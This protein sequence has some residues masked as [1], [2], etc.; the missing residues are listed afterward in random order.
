MQPAAALKAA[1][2]INNSTT[3][4][5]AGCNLHYEQPRV[6]LSTTQCRHQ[7]HQKRH[8]HGGCYYQQL[9]QFNENR[10]VP[11]A[12]STKAATTAPDET[13]SNSCVTT[14]EHLLAQEQ[15]QH[16]RL[17]QLRQRCCHQQVVLP[18]RSATSTCTHSCHTCSKR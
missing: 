11:S 4:R 2:V 13:A 12:V 15:Q 18:Q 16:Q 8:L 5:L 9:L 7:H 1:S 17:P 10:S 3:F 14:C 6:A